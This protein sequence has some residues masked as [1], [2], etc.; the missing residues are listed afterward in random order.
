MSLLRHAKF[1]RIISKKSISFLRI[2][3]EEKCIRTIIFQNSEVIVAIKDL[4]SYIRISERIIQK[5]RAGR[6]FVKTLT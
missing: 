1:N 5:K 6:D 3:G 2:F 4:L